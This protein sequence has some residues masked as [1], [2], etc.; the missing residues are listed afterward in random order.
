MLPSEMALLAHGWPRKVADNPEGAAAAA[1]AGGL[2][3]SM[4]SVGSADEEGQLIEEQYYLP[5][6]WGPAFPREGGWTS[7]PKR[8]GTG[9]RGKSRGGREVLVACVV[10]AWWVGGG[11]VD[12]WNVG[13]KKGITLDETPMTCLGMY[14]PSVGV[15]CVCGGE[16][17][18]AAEGWRQEGQS[19]EGLGCLGFSTIVLPC[20]IPSSPPLP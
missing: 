18:R 20:C 19:I 5:G 4:S 9:R 1:A 11:G 17:S 8:A 13:R 14:R 6:G 7:L 12:K 16:G 2:V 15:V 3:V 10:P